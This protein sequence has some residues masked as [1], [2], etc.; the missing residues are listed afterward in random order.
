MS[1]EPGIIPQR[2]DTWVH[3]KNPAIVVLVVGRSEDTVTVASE[4]SFIDG[5][6]SFPLGLFI[7]NFKLEVRP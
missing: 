7:R 3:Q 1:A 4:S 6:A 5:R 2:L